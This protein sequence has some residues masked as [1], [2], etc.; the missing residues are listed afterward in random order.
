MPCAASTCSGSSAARRSSTR[1]PGSPVWSLAVWG[2]TQ[3][4]H[5][6]WDGF[7]FYDLIFPLFLF[8]AGV[9][10]PFSLTGRLERGD[11]KRAL[12]FHVVRRGLL[13]VALGIVY[14]NG[15]FRVSAEQMRYPSV[16]GRIGLAYMFAALIVLNTRRRAQVAWFVSLLLGYWAAMTLIPVPGHGAGQLTV[17]GSLAGYLDR[18]LIPGRL[19]LGVHDPEGLLST[20]PAISTALLG[21]FAGHLLRSR[22]PGRHSRAQGLDPDRGRCCGLAVRGPL[23]SGLSDQ[24]EL[25][26]EL[27]RG[28]R[29]WV[30]LAPARRL[31]CGDRR[32]GQKAV[33]DVLRRDRYE[34]PSSST[35]PGRSSTSATRQTSFCKAC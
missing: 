10:M 19:H 35:W 12:I 33:G 1:S 29:R 14:N 5:V 27:F 31:L 18:L 3:L 4:H 25:V 30:E 7:V 23:G 20:I 9:A 16:L 26:D 32:M 17:D 11:D 24:Q 13:L 2:S 21:A 8:V 34:P 22:H 6:E 28:V 15:L